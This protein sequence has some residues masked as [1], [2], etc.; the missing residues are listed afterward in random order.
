[1]SITQTNTIAKIAAIVAGLGLVAMSF[2]SFAPA[3]KADT[4][5]TTTT[6]TSS[7]NFMVNLTVGSRGVD[8]T[9]LQNWLISKGY[10][11]PAGATGYFGGQTKAAVASWQAAAGISPAVGFFGPISRAKVNA[12]GGAVSSSVPGCAAGA[13]YSSTTG[14]ACGSGSTPVTGLTGAGYLTNITTLG[15]IVSDVKEGDVGD[16]IIGESARAVNGDL[17]VQRLDVTFDLSGATTGSTNLIRYVNSVS[18]WLGNTKLA[19]MNPADGSYQNKVWTLRFNNLNGVIKSGTTGNIHVSVDA[20]NSVNINEAGQTVKASLLANALRVTDANGVNDT[21][22][23]VINQNFTVSAANKGKLTLTE[24][25]DD[26]IA[27]TIKADL[28]N[29]TTNVTLLAFNAKATNQNVTLRAIPVG[30]TGT[31]M[32]VND[33]IQSIAL[34]QGGNVLSTKTLTNATGFQ[35]V[36]FDNLT[37]AISKDA[38]TEYTVVATMKKIDAG[39]SNTFSSGDGITATTTATGTA[40]FDVS[41]AQGNTVTPTGAVQGRVQTF[42]ALG[43]TVTQVSTTANTNIGTIG[44]GDNTQYGITFKMTAGDQDLYLSRTI[45]RSATSPASVTWATTTSSTASSTDQGTAGLTAADTNSGDLTAVYKI[46]AGSTRTFTLNVTLV[47]KLVGSAGITGVQ[48]TGLGYG[49]T[50]SPAANYLTYTSGL[51]QFKTT[52]KSMTVH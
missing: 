40:N 41:D 51:D 12:G 28:N 30:I 43:I 32:N 34:M 47:E 39:G 38:T 25:S 11:I 21:Y 19:T 5:T 4:M 7:A 8:V 29:T 9:A 1:M 13:M 42:Q 50:T 45:A 15:D 6:T 24:A 17:A 16:Q 26:P 20:V 44:S 23:T 22:G 46:P 31:G 27:T 36:V 3:A 2:A 37:Q 14:Q 33:A 49:T 35:E 10:S 52:D 48:L 18:V